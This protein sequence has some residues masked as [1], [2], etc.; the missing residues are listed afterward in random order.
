VA[1]KQK[2]TD[3]YKRLAAKH[4]AFVEKTEQEKTELVEARV[5][6]GKLSDNL[7]PETRSR[8]T[9]GFRIFRRQ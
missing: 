1:R 7:D 3:G 2:V 4:Q 8:C 9:I 6:L 5:E